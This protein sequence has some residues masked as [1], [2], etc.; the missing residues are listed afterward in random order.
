MKLYGAIAFGAK[1]EEKE[2]N[3][4]FDLGKVHYEGW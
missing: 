1:N 4:T 3:E 2:P